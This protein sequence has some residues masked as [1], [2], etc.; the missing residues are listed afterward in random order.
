MQVRAFWNVTRSRPSHN[1][2]NHEIVARFASHIQGLDLWH[3]LKF[4]KCLTFVARTYS[5]IG[6]NLPFFGHGGLDESFSAS[7]GNDL[8]GGTCLPKTVLLRWTEPI[9]SGNIRGCFNRR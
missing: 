7:T 6:L 4:F 3:F 9:A 5:S 2:P 8:C 1:C